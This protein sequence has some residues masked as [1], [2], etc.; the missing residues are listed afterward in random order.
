MSNT[1]KEY[2]ELISLKNVDF[3]LCNRRYSEVVSFADKVIEATTGDNLFAQLRSF[4]HNIQS[5]LNIPA[6]DFN[7][8]AFACVTTIPVYYVN[9]FLKKYNLKIV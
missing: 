9:M 7:K 3:V 8:T 5:D 4:T 2:Y 1:C 6:E